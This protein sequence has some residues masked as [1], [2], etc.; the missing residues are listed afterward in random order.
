MNIKL[1]NAVNQI[2]NENVFCNCI[3]R[4][5]SQYTRSLIEASHDP[6]FTIN[7]EG[8]ITDIN[9]ASITITDVTRE[10][11]IGTDF[12]KRFCG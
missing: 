1:L 10:K 2:H 7:P 8:K 11:L 12:C 4:Q 3:G 9:K 6:L 5:E